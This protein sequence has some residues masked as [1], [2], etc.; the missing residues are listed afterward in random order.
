MEYIEPKYKE[1]AF[2]CPYCGAYAQQK[3]YIGKVEFDNYDSCYQIESLLRIENRPTFKRDSG[4][5]KKMDDIS[6]S[7]CKKCNRYHIWYKGEMIV[8]S[9]SSVAMPVEGMPETVKKLYIEAR[10]V[11]PISSK[12]ACA[13]LRLAVQHLCI[14][15]GEKGKNINEDIGN[16]VKKGLPLEVQQA[17]DIVRVVGNN[18]VHP[19]VM[20]EDD[21]KDY[22][23]KI[24]ELLNFIVI[25]R[26]IRPN[27]IKKIFN[28]LPQ[29][30]LDAIEKRD[31]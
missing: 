14:E 4:K 28:G 24:F 20:S 21:T 1:N 23:S 27:E 22:A 2:N 10:N 5:I 3:W 15:L 9:K 31:K 12:S 11:F 29:G 19:G 17:L 30:A 25:D 7:T 18:A 26:I 16:L 6:L 13:I 8:P